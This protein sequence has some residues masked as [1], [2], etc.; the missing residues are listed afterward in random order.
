MRDLGQS[1]IGKAASALLIAFMMTIMFGVSANAR[2]ISPDTWD[3]TEP[4]VGT[5]RYSYSENDPVNKSDP[6]GHSFS[7][8]ETD[9]SNDST[10]NPGVDSEGNK[11]LSK[12][13]TDPDTALQRPQADDCVGECSNVAQSRSVLWGRA[14]RGGRSRYNSNGGQTVPDRL[15]SPVTKGVTETKTGWRLGKTEYKKD[16]QTPNTKQMNRPAADEAE[17]R[18]FANGFMN[19]QK[20]PTVNLPGNK[21]RSQ[22]GK[23][24]YRAN[25][26]DIQDKHLHIERL[27]PNTGRVIENYHIQW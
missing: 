16:F 11:D 21:V 20:Q 10:T 19:S 8:T 2:F 22:D 26:Q 9:F 23:W 15:S 13:A 1:I 14:S 3:P 4:G 18:G 12:N 6:N 7:G 25:K 17:A 24:Q 5:N 27:D